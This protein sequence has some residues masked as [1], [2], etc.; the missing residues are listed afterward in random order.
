MK[1]IR[2]VLGT[3]IL[4][5]VVVL[6]L[7]LT[8]NAYTEEE[9]QQAKAWLSAHGY[10]P[11]MGGASQAYQDYLNGKFDEELGYD[12][13]GDGIPASTTEGTEANSEEK[14]TEG[15]VKPEQ[16]TSTEKVPSDEEKP[17]KD[18]TKNDTES[19]RKNTTSPI[20]ESEQQTEKSEQVQAMEE[21]PAREKSAVQ[22]ENPQPETKS[23][24]VVWYNPQKKGTY[25]DVLVVITL[26]VLALVVIS[27]FVH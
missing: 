16:E 27:I 1:Q 17:V 2:Y 7:A 5:L 12:T 21:I 18:N 20:T 23:E 6:N 26:A 24:N 22:K 10:S 13:N 14:T 4:L 8:A 19:N 11:D 3:L 9:K 15:S 25:Q